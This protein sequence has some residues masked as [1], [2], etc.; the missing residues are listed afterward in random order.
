MAKAIVITGAS[1]GIGRAAARALHG[2]GHTVVIVDR[3]PDKMEKVAAELSVDY[4][5][6]DF[7]RLDEVRRLADA[8]PRRYPQIDVLCNNADG[9]MT[10]RRITEDGHEMTLQVNHFAPYLLTTLL[11][12]VLIESKATVVATSSSANRIARLE[13][14]DLNGSRRFSTGNAYAVAKLAN[15]MFTSELDRRYGKAGISAASFSPARLR[16]V[17]TINPRLSAD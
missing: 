4:Y 1:D 5:L 3:S 12:P 17:S 7:A 2:L 11:L 9:I 10:E 8:L 13:L 6:C 14:D 15:T 16:P